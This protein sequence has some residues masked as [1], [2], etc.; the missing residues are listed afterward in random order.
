VVQEVVCEKIG[1]V[2]DPEHFTLGAAGEPCG[3]SAATRHP[4][5]VAAA[6]DLVQCAMRSAPGALALNPALST[7]RQKGTRKV[8]ED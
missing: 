5:L 3:E 2:D 8:F 1:A 7:M 6:G 4:P